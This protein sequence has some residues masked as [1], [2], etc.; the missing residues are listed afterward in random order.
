ML[1]CEKNKKKTSTEK[2]LKLDQILL[3]IPEWALQWQLQHLIAA[4]N[5]SHLSNFHR[6][7]QLTPK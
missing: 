5:N 2:L 4:L 7:H 3:Y 1:W 6:S